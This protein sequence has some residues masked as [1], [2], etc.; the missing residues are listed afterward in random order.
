MKKAELKVVGKISMEIAK[1]MVFWKAVVPWMSDLMEYDWDW[2]EGLVEII[3]IAA[4]SLA[5]YFCVTRVKG[6]VE[7][8]KSMKEERKN[9]KR[10]KGAKPASPLSFCWIFVNEGVLRKCGIRLK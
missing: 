10:G 1:L 4:V 9:L 6:F 7:E 3:M 8:L 2:N 5:G